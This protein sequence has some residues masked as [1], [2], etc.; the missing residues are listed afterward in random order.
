MAK[1]GSPLSA[2]FLKNEICG[3]TG[4]IRQ[5]VSSIRQLLP[6]IMAAHAAEREMASRGLKFFCGRTTNG[7]EGFGH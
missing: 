4:R 5:A 2:G 3:R 6:K 1:A 7:S